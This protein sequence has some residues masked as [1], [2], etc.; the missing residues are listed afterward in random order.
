MVTRHAHLVDRL[1]RVHHADHVR[2]PELRFDPTRDGRAGRQ[3]R[4]LFDVIV[5]E[6]DREQPNVVFRGFRSFIIVVADRPRRAIAARYRAAV[7]LHELEG[8]DV[9]RLAV[10]ADLEIGLLQIGDRVAVAIAG[11]H[12][13]AHEVDARAEQRGCGRLVRRWI[14]SVGWVLLRGLTLRGGR[15]AAAR[16]A[17]LTA[18]P[19]SARRLRAGCSEIEVAPKR[20]RPRSGHDGGGM[21]GQRDHRQNRADPYWSKD[22]CA[23]QYLSSPW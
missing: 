19:A 21:A 20:P 1:E 14:L 3:A 2:G 4:A 6:K 16:L 23:C 22:T 10:L 11:D 15:A 13:H 5:V 7:E 8:L 17:R 9:L 12:V 18:L